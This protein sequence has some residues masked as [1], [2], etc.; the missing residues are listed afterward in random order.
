MSA[1]NKS[2]I[3]SESETFVKGRPRKPIGSLSYATGM[4]GLLAAYEAIKMI[5]PLGDDG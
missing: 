4:F 1:K 5:A 2:A 3:F